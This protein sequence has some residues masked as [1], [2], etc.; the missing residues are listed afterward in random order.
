MQ[1][2]AHFY[3]RAVQF[4]VLMGVVSL[5]ADMVYEGGRSLSGQYLA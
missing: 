4:I 3:R 2:T 1:T 5:L